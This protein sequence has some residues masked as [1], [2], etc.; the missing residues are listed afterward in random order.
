MGLAAGRPG[1]WTKGLD[2]QIGPQKATSLV[3]NDPI[4]VQ[5]AGQTH[6]PD[7]ANFTPCAITL[8]FFRL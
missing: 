1:L 6:D 7:L 8:T 2:Q 5:L 4:I 3:A